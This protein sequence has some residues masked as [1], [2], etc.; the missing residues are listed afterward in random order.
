MLGAVLGGWPGGIVKRM[1]NAITTANDAA[2][3]A[4]GDALKGK[5]RPLVTAFA[6]MGVAG[7]PCQR[8]ARVATEQDAPNPASAGYVRSVSERVVA[9]LAER[10][11]RASIVRL[12]PSVHGQG[13]KGLIPQL[14]DAARKHGEVLYVGDGS[15]RWP[16]VHRDD[17]AT[18][19]RLA[20]EQGRAGGVFHGVG[21]AGLT[22]RQIVEIMGRRLRLLVR[23]GTQAEAQRQLGWVAPFVSVD[24]P[25]SSDLTRQELGWAP[26]GPSLAEDLEGPAYF[27]R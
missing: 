3:D 7:A 11:V 14:A 23:S 4:L 13:D 20:L 12:P 26:I 9:R 21:D 5:D 22:Y 1:M 8:A 25:A 27:A 2:I 16:G 6:T 19:F 10:D 18:L 24:N 17:A 15:N